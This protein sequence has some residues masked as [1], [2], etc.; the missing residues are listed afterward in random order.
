[1]RAHLKLRFTFIYGQRCSFYYLA[2][3][4]GFMLDMSYTSNTSGTNN[5][6]QYKAAQQRAATPGNQQFNFERSQEPGEYISTLFDLRILWFCI[7]HSARLWQHLRR[8]RKRAVH[9]RV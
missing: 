5:G 8:R 9:L 2:Q 4:L 3:V 6:P 7:R 1:M